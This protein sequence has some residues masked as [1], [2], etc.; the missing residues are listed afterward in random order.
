MTKQLMYTV[1]VAGYGNVRTPV[2]EIEENKI[3]RLLG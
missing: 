1:R 2:R 3:V